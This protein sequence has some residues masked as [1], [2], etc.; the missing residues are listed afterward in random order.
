MR[1]DYD[2]VV[3]ML[4]VLYGDDV[5]GADFYTELFPDNEC[6][7]GRGGSSSS[8]SGRGGGG[9]SD[10]GRSGGSSAHQNWTKGTGPAIIKN[11]QKL[12]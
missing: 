6:S 7:S 9:S 2:D 11:V 10:G 12:Y 5:Y 3:D 4:G 1:T 8:S